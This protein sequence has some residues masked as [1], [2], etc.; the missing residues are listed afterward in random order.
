MDTEKPETDEERSQNV[1]RLDLQM[2]G[3]LTPESLQ[4]V[5]ALLKGELHVSELN[6]E[7]EKLNMP[8][9]VT[10]TLIIQETLP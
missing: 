9:E 4:K 2:Y 1:K 10:A 6:L 3:D 8:E 5:D 7:F